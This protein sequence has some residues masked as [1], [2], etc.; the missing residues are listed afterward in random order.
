MLFSPVFVKSN[1]A[2]TTPTR[3]PQSPLVNSS[4][5]LPITR[6]LFD[7]PH[8]VSSLF[9]TLTDSASCKSFSCHSYENMGGVYELFPLWNSALA[10][11]S[12][13]TCNE[14]LF[15]RSCRYFHQ[16]VSGNSFAASR[17]RTLSKNC[18]V[19]G[20]R[21]IATVFPFYSPC[22]ILPP[23]S[24]E[25]LVTTKPLRFCDIQWRTGQG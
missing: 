19:C 14:A 8:T 3:T 18:R 24:S 25:G 10:S 16:R 12:L 2:V 4:P 5:L 11:K 7:F 20:H 15:A 22:A 21:G 13:F 6:A 9:A 1:F 17:I 23:G